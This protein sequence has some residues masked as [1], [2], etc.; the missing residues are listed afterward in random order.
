MPCCA[1]NVNLDGACLNRL[2]IRRIPLDE[3]AS[4]T[5]SQEFYLRGIGF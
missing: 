1:G 2:R 5:S 3:L 4:L